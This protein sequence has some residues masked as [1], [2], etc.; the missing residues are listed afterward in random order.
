MLM[1]PLINIAI[2]LIPYCCQCNF[3]ANINKKNIENLSN[4]YHIKGLTY[5]QNLEY[6]KILK[7]LD[8]RMR[9]LEK[10]LKMEYKNINHKDIWNKFYKE[11]YPN[12]KYEIRLVREIVMDSNLMV[13]M[14]ISD[15]VHSSSYAEKV[16][17]YYLRK[18]SK[19]VRTLYKSGIVR[20]RLSFEKK[21]GEIIIYAGT[22]ILIIFTKAFFNYSPYIE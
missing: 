18:Y 10:R 2:T 15:Q 17:I 5:K 1:P 20:N 8:T 6:K 12:D 4:N 14:V 21:D 9:P 19:R 7:D 16:D 13:Y 22:E 3:D 11:N